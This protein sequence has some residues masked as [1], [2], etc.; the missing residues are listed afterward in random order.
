[1]CR[2]VAFKRCGPNSGT[3]P[4]LIQVV[5]VF[6]SRLWLVPG[7]KLCLSLSFK[8]GHPKAYV[9][10]IGAFFCPE[11]RAFTGFGARFLQPFLKSLVTVKCSSWPLIAVN[12]R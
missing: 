8:A 3:G 11:I 12:G 1:M 9:A 4:A 2:K 10:P 7:S 5:L 6:W